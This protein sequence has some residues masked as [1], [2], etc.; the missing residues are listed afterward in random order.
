M[1]EPLRGGIGL[2]LLAAEAAIGIVLARRRQFA[3]RRMIL[4]ALGIA[5]G[6]LTG[7]L[8][9]AYLMLG[10]AV[11]RATGTGRATGSLSW[12]DWFVPATVLGGLTAGTLLGL[13]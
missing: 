13:V 5:L 8:P 10:H 12:P 11:V 3:A 2:L 1:A 6:G 7:I 4:T 9:G